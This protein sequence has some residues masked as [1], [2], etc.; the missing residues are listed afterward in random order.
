MGD[1]AT[2]TVG[3]MVNILVDAYED[4][5]KRI[6]AKMF[7]GPPGVGK[8]M[9]VR[10]AAQKIAERNGWAYSEDRTGEDVFTVIDVRASQ[11]GEA[12]V[13]GVPFPDYER[14]ATRWLLPEFLPREGQGILFLDEVNLAPPH[15]QSQ[16]Y[17]LILDRKI[18][19]YKLPEGWMVVAAGNREEDMAYVEDMAAPLRNRMAIYHV[20][21]DVDSWVAWA[22]KNGIDERVI[23]FVKETGK[24]YVP[25]FN[26][27]NFPSPRT[28]EFVSHHMDIYDSGD[29]DTWMATVSGLVGVAAALEF[30]TFLESGSTT[31]EEMLRRWSLMGPDEK[32]AAVEKIIYHVKRDPEKYR[33]VADVLEEEYNVYVLKVLLREDESVVAKLIRRGY[34]PENILHVVTR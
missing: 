17:Q 5:K 9:A 2:I 1:I 13:R 23:A 20:E 33:L 14:G 4:R 8:S 22:E 24:L 32:A 34:V 21:P 29:L 19:S 18:G 30:K 11:L 6:V 26:D 12:D 27:R 3:Q 15:V 31:L 28:W 10:E 25:A 16:L 7:L